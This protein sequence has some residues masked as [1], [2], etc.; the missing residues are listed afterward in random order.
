MRLGS[1]VLADFGVADVVVQGHC[2]RLATP[3]MLAN[4][5]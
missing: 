2:G 5:N 1:A 4:I 3:I